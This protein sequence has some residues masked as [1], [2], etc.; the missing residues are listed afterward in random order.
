MNSV[1]TGTTV[2]LTGLLIKE[3]KNMVTSDNN[4]KG[5]WRKKAAIFFCNDVFLSNFDH[6]ILDKQGLEK[7]IPCLNQKK[8]KLPYPAY[9]ADIAY[10][11]TVLQVARL[12]V[13]CWVSILM[14]R[15]L[16]VKNHDLF[17]MEGRSLFFKPNFSK[18]VLL[19]A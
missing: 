16:V 14:A 5:A 17:K 8:V 7:N 12:V 6:M 19:H 1:H 3:Q 9:C 2:N 10:E 11:K 18:D 4:Q 13:F 15:F